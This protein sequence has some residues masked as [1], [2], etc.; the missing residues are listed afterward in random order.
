MTGIAPVRAQDPQTFT[1]PPAFVKR[2]RALAAVEDILETYGYAQVMLVVD[3]TVL[4]E[5]PA[6]LAVRSGWPH[7]RRLRP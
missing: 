6:G 4:E 5:G 3:P 7:S 1:P 2:A